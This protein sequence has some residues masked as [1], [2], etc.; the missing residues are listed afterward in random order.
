MRKGLLSTGAAGALAAVNVF[1]PTRFTLSPLKVAVPPASV[2]CELVPLRVPDPFK[3][4][5]TDAPGTLLP[6]L[7]AT[8]TVTAGV[9]AAPAVVSD[10]C[11]VK[12]S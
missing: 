6:K 5:D 2:V 8:W 11:W 12:V 10:G 4:T 3:L 1:D 9:I 7:S